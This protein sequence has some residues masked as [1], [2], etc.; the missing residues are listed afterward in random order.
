MIL[1]IITKI[2]ASYCGKLK[3]T[4]TNEN[5]NKVTCKDTAI[6]ILFKSKIKYDTYNIIS[7]KGLK[8]DTGFKNC[9]RMFRLLLQLSLAKIVND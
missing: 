3:K 1:S 7:S 8:I 4:V 9:I 5:P 2:D 6:M